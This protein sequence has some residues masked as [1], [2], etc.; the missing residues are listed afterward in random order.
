MKKRSSNSPRACRKRIFLYAHSSTGAIGIL[1]IFCLAFW[2][3]GCDSPSASGSAP[4]DTLA[5]ATSEN[6][7]ATSYLQEQA[8]IKYG[9]GFSLEYH[10]HYKVVNILHN[11]EEHTDTLR[12]VLVRRGTPAPASYPNSQ[13]IEIPVRSMVGMSSMHIA[14]ADYAESADLLVG[15]GSLKYV[16]SPLVRKNIAEG[17]VL[18]TGIGA[19][20]NDELLISMQPELVMAMGSP[21]ARISRYETLTGAGIA[22]LINTEWLETSPLGRAEWVKLM[23]A[24]TDQEALVNRKFSETADKYHRLAALTRTA[25]EK[26]MV[27]AG[28]PYKGTW[29][30]PDGDSF[31]GQFLRDAGTTYHWSETV[32]KGSL[33]LDFESVYPIALKA[34]FWINTG[35]VNDLQEI[36][37]TD[38]RFA[39]FSAF[40]QKKVFNNN[41]KVNDLGANDYWESGAV[42]PHLILADLIKI[43]HPELLPEHELVYYK[44][45]R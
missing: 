39:D 10:D 19:A 27:V 9:R 6:I 36:K 40:K 38:V 18:E 17:K 25:K 45:L 14:L 20:A 15:L 43:F 32:E 1:F 31:V 2:L 26:P 35:Y 24:L 34:D 21:D 12:Y 13:I 4:A 11:F 28:M 42:N 37:A 29:F 33:P 30:V 44:S 7:S 23:A 8:E 41:K 3:T 5:E 22:V 16:S